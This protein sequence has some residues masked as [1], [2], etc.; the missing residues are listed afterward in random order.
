MLLLKLVSNNQGISL[1]MSDCQLLIQMTIDDDF[2]LALR[3]NPDVQSLDATVHVCN[4][5]GTIKVQCLLNS[6]T[7]SFTLSVV[8]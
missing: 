4:F 6:I 1:R 7:N 5:L 8:L 2:H 3:G